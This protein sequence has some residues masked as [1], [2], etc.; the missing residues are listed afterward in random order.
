MPDPVVKIQIEL[1]TS[2]FAELS[3][4]QLIRLMT[5]ACVAHDHC[6][7]EA[8]RRGL[9]KEDRLSLPFIPY[10]LPEG[11]DWPETILTRNAETIPLN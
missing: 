1:D 3:D 5:L 6:L 2:R 10:A 7:A 4:E 8:E 9:V 11:M